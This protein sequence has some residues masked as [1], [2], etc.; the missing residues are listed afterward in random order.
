MPT[1]SF[2]RIAFLLSF[3]LILPVHAEIIIASG[4]GPLPVSAED[5]TGHLP[6]EIIG[7]IPDT[8]NGVNV[9]KIVISDFADFSAYTLPEAFGIPDTELFL[10]DA[11]GFGVYAN[12]DI[13]GGNTLSCLPSADVSNPCP[14]ARPAGVGPASNGIYYLAVTRSENSALSAG[15]NIFTILNFTDIVGPDTAAGGASPVIGWD[16]GGF[17]SPDTDLVKYDIVLTGAVPEPGTW[18]LLATAALA[19]VLLRRKTI[20]L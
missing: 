19:L 15:G 16:G 9:F 17:T 2:L 7:T 20:A 6:T 3:V 4:A 11:N 14:S 18:A 10:F 1:N 8:S 12:D 13:D 5:L